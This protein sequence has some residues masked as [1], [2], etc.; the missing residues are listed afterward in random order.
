MRQADILCLE[1][2]LNA[3]F[4][5]ACVVVKCAESIPSKNDDYRYVNKC[6]TA[7]CNVCNTPQEVGAEACANKDKEGRNNVINSVKRLARLSL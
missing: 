3:R 7:H 4:A 1:G 2:G 6:H 5:L